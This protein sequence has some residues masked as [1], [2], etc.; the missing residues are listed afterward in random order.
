MRYFKQPD[1]FNHSETHDLAAMLYRFRNDTL[2]EY[3]LR[4]L[5]LIS[6]QYDF[7]LSGKISKKSSGL[8]AAIETAYLAQADMICYRHP[9]FG[10]QMPL[11]HGS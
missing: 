3:E 2:W 1:P 6:T 8:H 5:R 11:R 9:A 7:D 4:E 10:L